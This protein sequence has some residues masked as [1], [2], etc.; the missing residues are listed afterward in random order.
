MEISKNLNLGI[1]YYH[2][3]RCSATRVGGHEGR[4]CQDLPSACGLHRVYR[5]GDEN[6]ADRSE[7]KHHQRMLLLE[8]FDRVR[9]LVVCTER[10]WRSCIY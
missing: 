10:G 8:K 6:K 7:C 2:L 3:S 5:R 1:H 9:C 4:P